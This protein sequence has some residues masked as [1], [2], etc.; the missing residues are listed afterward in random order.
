MFA[1]N[2]LF[3]KLGYMPKIDMQVG[4]VVQKKRI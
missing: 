2:W 4:K 1:I 3:D